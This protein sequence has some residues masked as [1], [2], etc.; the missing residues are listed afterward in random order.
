ML[1]VIAGG[2]L[3]NGLALDGLPMWRQVVFVGLA[4]AA[5]LHGR[6]LGVAR[7]WPVLVGVAA[8]AVGLMAVDLVE[9]AG[10]VA[11]LGVFVGLPW[12]AGRFRR[13]QALLIVELRRA[14]ELV[15]ERARLRERARIA[16]DVH[17]S[18]GHELALIA[19][20][21]GGLELAPDLS[22]ENRRAAGELRESAVVATDRLRRTVGLL[23]ETT[24]V[25]VGEGVAELVARAVDAGMVVRLEG[26]VGGLPELVDRAVHRVVQEGLTN[27]ARHAPGSE[28]GVTVSR[29]AGEVEVRVVNAL[30]G[31]LRSGAS[32][33]VRPAGPAAGGG[34]RPPSPSSHGGTTEDGGTRAEE[35]AG[36][37]L[38]GLRERVEL[39]GGVFRAG[40]DG[41]EFVVCARVP[42]RGERR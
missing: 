1:A 3:V 33:G 36:S 39:L 35:L 16:A 9:W 34:L 11:C 7:G 5:Y 12:G 19:L 13:Q 31:G 15:A 37:G 17:D 8:P 26:D 32:G 29:R 41:D 27:A 23:R 20:R 25:P 18:L 10:A 22:E 38:V 2:G 30:V 24:V 21:A 42:V 40:V 6:Y 4:V 14:Q 28:V